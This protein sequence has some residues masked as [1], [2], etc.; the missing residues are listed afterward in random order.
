M[1]VQSV[2]NQIQDLHKLNYLLSTK[3][4]D[5][6]QELNRVHKLVF[7]E[8]ID[9]GCGNCRIKAFHKLTSLTLDKLKEMEN[10]GYK[11]KKGVLIEF[12]VGSGQFYNSQSG[13]SD[14]KAKAYLKALPHRADNFAVIPVET[15]GKSL[16]SMNKAELQAKYKEV[17][18]EDAAEELTKKELISEITK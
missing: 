6:S 9:F 12:P 2:Y 3:D 1:D 5:A 18:G 16:E 7:G 14:E 11:I 17:K 4:K 15:E 8:A 13:I 10:Q